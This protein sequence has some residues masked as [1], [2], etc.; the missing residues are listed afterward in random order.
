MSV[1]A[2]CHLCYFE[3]ENLQG[4]RR[5]VRIAALSPSWREGFA[6]RLE[7]ADV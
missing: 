3:R 5:A 7:K 4:A 1:R 2:I 6:E